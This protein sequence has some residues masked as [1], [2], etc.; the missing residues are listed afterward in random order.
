MLLKGS[1]GV[2][3]ALEDLKTPEEII[4]FY[5]ELYELFKIE[6]LDKFKDI[7]DLR[8]EFQIERAIPYDYEDILIRYKQII[9]YNEH[10]NFSSKLNNKN[11]NKT[12]IP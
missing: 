10:I 1:E 2:T 9:T 11:F 6:I 4:D 5:N 3:P 8:R 7:Y 12:K